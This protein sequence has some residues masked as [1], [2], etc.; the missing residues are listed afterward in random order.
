[1][2]VHPRLRRS[3]RLLGRAAVTAA[4]APAATTAAGPAPAPQNCNQN[5][6]TAVAAKLVHNVLCAHRA[7]RDLQPPI[8]QHRHLLRQTGSRGGRVRERR[9][10][11]QPHAASA[12]SPGNQPR[13]RWRPSADTSA[14]CRARARRRL[15]APPP[16]P[17]A[18]HLGDGRGVADDAAVQLN[19]FRRLVVQVHRLV[20]VGGAWRGGERETGFA[21]RWAQCRAQW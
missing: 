9:L 19:K 14:S 12:G 13:G 21:E 3:A 18:A 8:H 20:L 10:A 15:G 5:A 17:Q 11:W 16:L 1:M 6:P 7:L 4:G 2:A